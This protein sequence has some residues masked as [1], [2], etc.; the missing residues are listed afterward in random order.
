MRIFVVGCCGRELELAPTRRRHTRGSSY[1][2]SEA[3]SHGEYHTRIRSSALGVDLA[4]NCDE[5]RY[6]SESRITQITRRTRN[7]SL[8]FWGF[9]GGRCAD[10][11][12]GMLRSRAGARSYKKKAHK[13]FLLQNVRGDKSW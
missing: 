4:M 9:M 1:R 12:S 13:R 7:L 3:T 5:T 10:F 6:L 11:C 2:M 8:D